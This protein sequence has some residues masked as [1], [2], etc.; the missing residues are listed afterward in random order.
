MNFG[1]RISLAGIGALLALLVAFGLM[2]KDLEWPHDTIEYK[3]KKFIEKTERERL[4]MG[5]RNAGDESS[6]FTV[7]T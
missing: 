1:W 2:I 7:S 5:L 6:V 4:L 3:K